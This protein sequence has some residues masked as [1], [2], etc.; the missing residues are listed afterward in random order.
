MEHTRKL[1]TLKSLLLCTAAVTLATASLAQDRQDRMQPQMQDRPAASQPNPGGNQPS[2]RQEPSEPKNAPSQ[3]WERGTTGQ[4]PSEPAAPRAQERNPNRD[5]QTPAANENQRPSRDNQR[6]RDNQA[7]PRDSER[8]QQRGQAGDSNQRPQRDQARDQNRPQ[9]RN[10][11]R[12]NAQ[13][14]QDR[15]GERNARDN[16]RPADRQAAQP[17]EQQRSRISTSIRQANVQPLRN[18]NFSVSVGT[19]IPASVRLHPVTPAIVAVY[20]QYRGYNFVLVNDE[21]VII[22]PRTKR[23]V[24]VIHEGG[25]A[26]AAS[27]PRGRLTLNERQRD[28]IRRSALQRETTGSGSMTT[29]DREIEVGDDL[30]DTVEF[31]SFPEAV[32]SEVPEIRSYRYIVRDRDIYLVEPGE[33]RVIEVIR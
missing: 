26:R 31:E 4:A 21:I 11:D 13:S 5:A 3:R 22:E 17:S 8:N 32:Y 25:G 20:P 33:R 27:A 10:Q 14:Q 1:H 6:L 30:P 12:N 23:I 7:Q 24:T 19:T 29:I 9:D 2:M 28:V 15:A 18:A 16:A